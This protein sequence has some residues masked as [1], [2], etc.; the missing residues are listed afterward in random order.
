MIYEVYKLNDTCGH[1]YWQVVGVYENVSIDEA[2]KRYEAE[3]QFWIHYSM[4]L[5]HVIE[6]SDRSHTIS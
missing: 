5:V 1:Y 6:L 4:K 2:L 3:K